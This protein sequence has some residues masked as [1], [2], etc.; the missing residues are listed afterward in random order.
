MPVELLLLLQCFYLSLFVLLMAR[1]AVNEFGG[2]SNDGIFFM[3]ACVLPSM[4]SLFVVVPP[5]LKTL[6]FL[7]SCAQT[8]VEI[9]EETTEFQELM[10]ADFR[11]QVKEKMKEMER[12]LVGTEK[13]P[14]VV[15]RL[16][17]EVKKGTMT[18]AQAD[19]EIANAF[20]FLGDETDEERIKDEMAWPELKAKLLAG[21]RVP[22]PPRPAAMMMFWNLDDDH[23]GDINLEELKEGMERN[24]I[25][26]REGQGE[27]L[28]RCVDN[29][30]DGLIDFD[31]FCEVALFAADDDEEE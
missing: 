19:A 27:V 4:L 26:M 18:K 1:A 2:D 10:L 20:A 17:K 11:A 3:V 23:G 25:E 7:I 22:L 28:L 13:R 6:V 8:N 9:K 30:G 14:G 16:G 5:Q 29:S 31:E 24:G 21:E 15:G 12:D